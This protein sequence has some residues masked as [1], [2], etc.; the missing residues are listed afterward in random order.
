MKLELE[1]GVYLCYTPVF[2]IN[3]VDA[4]SQDFGYQGDDQPEEAAPYCCGDMRFV[5]RE[6]TP[7]VLIKYG[8]TG[9]EYEL[10]AGQLESGLSF[11]SCGRCS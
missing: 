6:A 8:I 7:D 11:G 3:G 5:R 1:F 10:I 2:R 4:D 9:P